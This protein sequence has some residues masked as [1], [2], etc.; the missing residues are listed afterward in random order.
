MFQATNTKREFNWWF[1]YN[2]KFC[3]QIPWKRPNPKPIITSCDMGSVFQDSPAKE[4]KNQATLIRA[5]FEMTLLELRRQIYRAKSWDILL[6]WSENRAILPSTVSSQ[7]IRVIAELCNANCN[8]R[9]K[10]KLSIFVCMYVCIYLCVTVRGV[11]RNL[12]RG[13]KG[14]WGTEILQRGL[15]AEWAWGYSPRSWR[16]LM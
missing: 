16:Q 10:S 4:V 13:Q 12:L 11:A 7:Y 14:V 15:R 9:L 5:P 3:L 2:R 6:L 8:V 1:L